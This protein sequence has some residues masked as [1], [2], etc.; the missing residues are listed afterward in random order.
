VLFRTEG[1]TMTESSHD[2]PAVV[3]GLSGNGLG[4]ARSLGRRGVRVIA[5]TDKPDAPN[6][7]SRYVSE[8]WPF[9]GTDEEMM[10]MLLERGNEFA[11]RPVLFPIT[12]SGVLAA[13]DRLSEM[14]RLYRIGM[15][16]QGALVRRMLCKTG[17]AEIAAEMGL[18]VPRS[19][20]VTQADQMP[21]V[22]VEVK[23][24]CILKPEYRSSAFVRNAPAK[25]FYAESADELLTWYAGFSLAAPEVVVQEYIPG[26]DNE[27]YFCFQCYDTSQQLLASLS[28]RKMRQWPP[29]CGS[30]SSCEVVR[31]NQLDDMA[32]AFFRRI[33]Y[34]GP[35]SMEYKRDSRD[36]SLKVIEPTIGRTDWNNSFAEHNGVPLP[37]IAYCA[38]AGLPQPRFR[39]RR[40]SR[41]WIRWSADSKAA[42]WYRRQGELG[43]AEWL[44][45]IR[46]PWGWARWCWHDPRPTVSYF[47]RRLVRKLRKTLSCPSPPQKQDASGDSIGL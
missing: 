26:G 44:W 42:A 19:F 24:P 34:V 2:I 29:R 30:T 11:V 45:S 17:F 1:L 23:Y 4:V 20:F 22:A 33:G 10:D 31:M 7:H 37:Y 25:A 36:G 41:R 27:I 12:D 46:P 3:L 5:V 18:P 9:K 40:I 8:I 14:R 35:C 13:A 16:E 39:V 28:G 38:L 43:L 21:A 47:F 6:A 15:P 32:T